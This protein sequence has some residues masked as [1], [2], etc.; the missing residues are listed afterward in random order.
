MR[1]SLKNEIE[2][3][4]DKEFLESLFRIHRMLKNVDPDQLLSDLRK[5][6]DQRR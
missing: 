1:E 2:R 5:D 6:R 3:R 4:N